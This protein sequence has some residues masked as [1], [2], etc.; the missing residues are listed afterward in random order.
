MKSVLKHSKYIFDYNY[1]MDNLPVFRKQHAVE[2]L[3]MFYDVFE[4]IDEK[5]LALDTSEEEDLNC[6]D[7]SLLYDE[8]EDEC[9]EENNTSISCDDYVSNDWD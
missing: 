5:D 1:I 2:L 6:C 8:L 4:D 7:L 3:Y 9:F